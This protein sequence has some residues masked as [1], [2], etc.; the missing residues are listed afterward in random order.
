MFEEGKNTSFILYN[1]NTC[2]YE[3]FQI[4]SIIMISKSSYVI[5]FAATD[6]HLCKLEM[7]Y[8]HNK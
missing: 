3:E 8:F 5:L 2:I 7:K 4:I 6:I 1:R